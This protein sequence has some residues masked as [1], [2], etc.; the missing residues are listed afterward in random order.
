MERIDFDKMKKELHIKIYEEI[1][2]LMKYYILMNFMNKKIFNF[3][4]QLTVSNK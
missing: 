3:Q 1:K 2:K 4:L